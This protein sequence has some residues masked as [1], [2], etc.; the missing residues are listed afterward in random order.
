M[1]FRCSRVIVRLC[2]GLS[3]LE[4]PVDTGEAEAYHTLWFNRLTEISP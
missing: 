2:L 3:S 4:S 1:A